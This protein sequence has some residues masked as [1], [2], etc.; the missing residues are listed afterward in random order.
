MKTS[1]AVQTFQPITIT[2]ET[3]AEAR[4]VWH[5]FNLSI[6]AIDG[7]AQATEEGYRD[8]SG[9]DMLLWDA[10]NDHYDLRAIIKKEQTA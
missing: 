8:P 6:S 9:M 1:R 10:I 2:I 4:A 5:R 3:E 7:R